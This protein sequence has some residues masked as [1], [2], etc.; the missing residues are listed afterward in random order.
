MRRIRTAMLVAV[1]GAAGGAWAQGAPGKG[2]PRG[3]STSH[4]APNFGVRATQGAQDLERTPAPKVE[5]GISQGA[6]ESPSGGHTPTDQELARGVPPVLVDP[7][8]IE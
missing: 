8:P 6:A 4:P 1:L 2:L 3:M 5:K 7:G